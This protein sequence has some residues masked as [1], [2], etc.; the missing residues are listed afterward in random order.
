M[1]TVTIDKNGINIKL[2]KSNS[3]THKDLISETCYIK[4]I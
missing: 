3:E 2:S 4:E 1:K